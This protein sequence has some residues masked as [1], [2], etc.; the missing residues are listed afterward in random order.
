LAKKGLVNEKAVKAIDLRFAKA[1]LA[2]EARAIA[3]LRG[4]IGKAF[5][6]TVRMVLDLDGTGKGRV[7]TTGMGKAGFIAQKVFA[8]LASTGTPA[9]FLHPAE[10]LHGDLGMVK[11][12]DILIAFSNSGTSEEILRLIPPL[13]KLGTRIVAITGEGRS[14]LAQAAHL[15]LPIGQIREP[16]PMKLAPSASTTAM[17]AMGDA[18]A[19]TILKA[20]N[21]TPQ[22][23]ARIHPAGALGRKMLQARDL[24]RTGERLPLVTPDTLVSKVIHR[25]TQAR[26]GAAVIVGTKGRLK[27]IFTDGDFKRRILDDPSRIQQ[28]IGAYMTSPCLSVTDDCLIAEVQEIMAQKKINALPVVDKRGKAIG[29]L[30]IQDLVGWPT[31]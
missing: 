30:D 25:L 2:A 9:F 12:E 13:K 24:M 5:K 19:L 14:P 4:Y 20:R 16:C 3:G 22:D 10:A 17:L 18:L 11:A 6:Q 27:G 15:V 31:L 8:T 28:A 1:V 23:Y 26:S 29:L 7:V 21:F